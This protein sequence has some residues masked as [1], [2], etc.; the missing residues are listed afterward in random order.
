MIRCSAPKP[1]QQIYTPTSSISAAPWPAACAKPPDWSPNNPPRDWRWS[2]EDRRTV[3][4]MLQQQ[5]AAKRARAH[6]DPEGINLVDQL[7]R[8]LDYRFRIQ[9]QQDGQWRKL[10]GPASSLTFQCRSARRSPQAGHPG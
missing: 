4:V 5:I 2:A 8:T 1:S 9:R 3:G 10:S 7:A 6:D